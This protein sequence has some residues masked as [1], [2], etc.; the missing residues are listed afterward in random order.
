MQQCLGIREK[1][2][3][4]PGGLFT[5]EG[6]KLLLKHRAF[7]RISWNF[8]EWVALQGSSETFKLFNNAN[9]LV[10]LNS[11]PPSLYRPIRSFARCARTVV[12]T[13]YGRS[14]DILQILDFAISQHAQIFYTEKVSYLAWI[15]T[16][17]R[18]VCRVATLLAWRDGKM[19]ASAY[20]HRRII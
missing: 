9:L 8:V 16:K 15:G 20:H 11:V 6:P 12:D 2:A 13:R 7:L 19:L 18:I 3:M 1:Q 4:L 10:G 14:I 5:A 17:P